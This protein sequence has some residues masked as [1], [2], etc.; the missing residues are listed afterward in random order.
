[1]DISG[2]SFFIKNKVMKKNTIVGLAALLV[3]NVIWGIMAPLLKEFLNTGVMSG[4]TVSAMRMI[5]CT[6]LFWVTGWMLPSTITKQQHVEKKDMPWMFFGGILFIIGTQTLTNIGAEYTYPVDA[7]VCCSVTPIFTLLLGA[8]FVYH[9]FPS[10]VKI[11][12]VLLGLAGVLI[13]ILATDENPEMH[14]TNPFLGDL[15]CVLSQV[16][17]A[18]YLVFFAGLASRYSCFTLM[19][20][21][22]TFATVCILPFTA[23]DI[24]AVPWAEMSAKCWFILAYIIVLGSFVGYL[25]VAEAQKMVTPTVIAICNYIQPISAAIYAIIL[26]LAII[27]QANVLATA[28]IFL[29]VWLVNKEK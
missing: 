28:L 19:K 9:K 11:L 15:F 17:G 10:Y 2:S 4:M 3:A 1:M 5:V 13:F 16:C 12:G 23:A 25:L 8:V 20:W 14:V 29:G 22:Y 18:S 24:I 21:M 7:A 6:I 27:T 26:G